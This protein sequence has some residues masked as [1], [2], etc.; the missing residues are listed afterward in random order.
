MFKN[1]AVINWNNKFCVDECP[2]DEYVGKKYFLVQRWTKRGKTIFLEL[3]QW[4]Y[5]GAKHILSENPKYIKWAL[6]EVWLGTG[7]E[8]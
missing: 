1:D 3:Y 5:Q 4:S 7:E 8:D 6:V 2:F